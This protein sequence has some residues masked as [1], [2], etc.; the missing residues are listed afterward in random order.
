V[1]PLGQVFVKFDVVADET[2]NTHR[3]LPRPRASK[4]FE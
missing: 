3:N 2:K 4:L 1:L